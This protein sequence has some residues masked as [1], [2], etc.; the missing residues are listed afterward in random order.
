MTDPLSE[1]L[2][3]VR[4]TGAVFFSV[5]ASAPWVAEAPPSAAIAPHVLP[6]VE[7]VIEYHVVTAGSCWGGLLDEPALRLDAGDIIVF[8]QGDPHVMSSAPGMRGQPD[9]ELHQSARQGRL[10]ISISIQGGG[11]ER[12]E[13]ICGFLGCDAQPFNPLLATLPRVLH[14][15]GNAENSG[16]LRHLVELAV[17]ESSAPKAGGACALS[18]LSELLFVEVVRRYA[19]TLPADTVG[20]FAGLRDQQVGRALQKMHERPAHA[21][22][23]AELAK[24][25]GMSRSMLAER[26]AHFVGVPPMQYLAEWRIQL[27]AVLLRTSQM[28]LTEIAERVGY[29]S[30][31]A[32]SRAFKRCTGVAPTAYR[33]RESDPPD[34]PP[35]ATRSL[36]EN[37]QLD[38]ARGPGAKQLNE[39]LGTT[40]HPQ[41]AATDQHPHDGHGHLDQLRLDEHLRRQDFPTIG[42]HP[43][44]GDVSRRGRHP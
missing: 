28:N 2:R 12:T 16:V 36:L 43:V 32:L 31:S 20:W 41:Y 15:R 27:A 25:V 14:L 11:S 37:R 21:W 35:R 10:P 26:F 9:L 5:D 33:R 4:L 22:S 17:A 38:Q 8:P 44:E 3:A 19:A 23:L 7:H 29:G 42:P 18:R 34:A 13:V 30:E 39:R 6:G 24:Q 1:V 40:V